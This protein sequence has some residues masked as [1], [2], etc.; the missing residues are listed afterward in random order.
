MQFDYNEFGHHRAVVF[1]LIQH[2]IVLT[3]SFMH[4]ID[5]ILIFIITQEFKSLQFS[6]SFFF[7]II[8]SKKIYSF[9]SDFSLGNKKWIIDF[10]VHWRK[11]AEP[12]LLDFENHRKSLI[13]HCERSELRL[14]F[15]WTKVNWK[16]G[17][18]FENLK[19]AVKQCYQTSQF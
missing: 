7:K 9:F 18:F 11:N 15:E 13:Q 4:Y 3:N 8:S 6:F 19:L 14:H 16:I 2:S 1:F 5:Y 10:G 12:S 17:E